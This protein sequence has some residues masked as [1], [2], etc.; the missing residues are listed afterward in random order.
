MEKNALIIFTRNPVYGEVK[1]RIAAT[2]GNEAALAVYNKLLE[3]TEAITRPLHCDKFVYYSEKVGNPDIWDPAMFSKKVQQGGNLGERM[4]AAFQD[5]FKAGYAQ[6]VIIGSDC[7]EL[8]SGV[9]GQAFE[10]LQTN[11]LVVGPATDGGY[12][13]LGI[14]KPCPP[15]FEGKSW[16]TSTL[17][18]ETLKTAATGRMSFCL[19]PVLNDIDVKED[20]PA[21]LMDALRSGGY[22]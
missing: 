1:T 12:Y 2:L 9:I 16:S 22:L 15:L 20:I 6:V 21:Q 3:H 5:L 18:A 4:H 10:L 7:Y 17:L 14:K 11:D 19:L 13:L 8:T